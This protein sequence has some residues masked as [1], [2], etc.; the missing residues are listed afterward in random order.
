[1]ETKLSQF[2]A[3]VRSALLVFA[4]VGLAACSSNRYYAARV[5]P[6]PPPGAYYRVP[7]PG[8]GH[9]WRGGYYD[10][11]RRG[12]YR[13]SGGVWVRPPRAGAVWV[14]PGWR[15]RSWRRGGWR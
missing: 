14:N 13:W 10:W 5:V 7:S 3:G 15:G 11:D 2:A 4:M 12:G 9:I 1:M 6:A 8:P